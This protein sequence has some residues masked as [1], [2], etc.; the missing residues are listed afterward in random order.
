MIT[1]LQNVRSSCTIC[2]ISAALIWSANDGS[3]GAGRI[4]RPDGSWRI[5]NWLS[6]VRVEPIERPDRVHDRVLRGQLEHHGD[7]AELQ[8]GV[9]QHDRL[10]R[11]PAGQHHGQVGGQDGLARPALGGE[12]RDDLARG[13]P[14]AT[15]SVTRR[16]RPRRSA[17]AAD[18]SSV[19]ATRATAVVS[20][21]V[22]TGAASTSFTPDRRAV[23]SRSV[24]SSSVTRIVPT[25]RWDCRVAPISASDAALAQDGPST[26]TVGPPVRRSCSARDRVD[27]HGADPELRHHLVAQVQVIVEDG[28]RHEVQRVGSDGS[29]SLSQHGGGWDVSRPEN[30]RLRPPVRAVGGELGAGLARE[31]GAGVERRRGPS[32]GSPWPRGSGRTAPPSTEAICWAASAGTTKVIRPELAAAAGVPSALVSAVSPGSSLRV[33]PDGQDLDLLVQHPGRLA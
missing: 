18:T 20:C 11:A 4:S 28:H 13:R 7:V 33:W 10:L 6:S 24:D 26:R 16:G 29:W 9:D 21:S 32:A 2:T 8:V 5:R 30:L 25:S 17:G 27:R 22:S 31:G 19:S 14:S 3:S 23:C 15:P 12:D 1:A